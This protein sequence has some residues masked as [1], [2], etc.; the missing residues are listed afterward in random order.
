MKKILVITLLA[1]ILA[2]ECKAQLNLN[3]YL[4]E[5]NQ[6]NGL[7]I[8]GLNENDSLGVSVSFAGD[9]NGD[10][11]DDFIIGADDAGTSDDNRTGMAYVILGMQMD[12]QTH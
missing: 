12:I 8:D 9:V 1:F 4:S 5:I 11:I 3:L 10:G 6:D 7:V 2:S